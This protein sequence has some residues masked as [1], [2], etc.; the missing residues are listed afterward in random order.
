MTKEKIKKW[1][2]CAGIR[3]FKTVIQTAVSVIGVSTLITE[4]DWIA[5]LSTSVTAGILSLLTSLA[6]LPEIEKEDENN[7]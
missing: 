7:D 3:A 2:K 5:V 4:V 1:L 6:G